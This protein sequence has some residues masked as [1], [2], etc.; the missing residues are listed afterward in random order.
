MKNS[1][2]YFILILIISCQSQRIV[3]STQDAEN[4]LKQGNYTNIKISEYTNPGACEP[5][6]AI[7]PT[8]PKNIVAGNVL[9]DVH[10]SFD[11]GAT[12]KSS[13]IKSMHGV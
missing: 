6:I 7:N 5:S 11:G 8:N 12:W 10:V 9:K 13:K 1:I 2:F 3:T 4:S